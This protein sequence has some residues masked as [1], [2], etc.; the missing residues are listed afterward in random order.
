MATKRQVFYSFHYQPDNWRASKVRNIG[1]V[2]GNNPVSDNKWETI[3]EGG[4]QAI[5][6]WINSQMDYRSCA[7]VL[8][9]SN[10][11]NRKWINYEIVKAW[12]DNMGVVGIHI[13]D[14]K[15]RAGYTS[16]QGDNPFDYIK[17]GDS[18]RKLSSIAKCYNPQGSNSREVYD[19]I[20]KWL[21]DAVEEA[22][23]IR[24]KN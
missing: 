21:S 10:T 16:R 15:D 18:G 4:E 24:E 12:K 20:S 23:R 22:I 14:L 2:G 13:H 1:V 19:W 7:V 11:T 9:G 3:K 8:V 6:R 5:K 17:Y